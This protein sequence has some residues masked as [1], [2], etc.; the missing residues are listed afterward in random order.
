VSPGRFRS[1][2]RSG[3]PGECQ[4][5]RSPYRP[6]RLSLEGQNLNDTLLYV[7]SRRSFVLGLDYKY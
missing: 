4:P 3:A 2:S 5:A 1:Q 6:R 7:H